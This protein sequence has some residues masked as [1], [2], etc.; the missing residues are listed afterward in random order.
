[1]VEQEQT[2][3]NAARQN[4][5]QAQTEV[6]ARQSQLQQQSSILQSQQQQI[7]SPA[8]SRALDISGMRSRNVALG[9]IGS[10]QAGVQQAQ[11]QLGAASKSLSEYETNVLQPIEQQIKNVQA[12]QAEWS[13]AFTIAGTNIP[14]TQ[15]SKSIQEKVDLIRNNQAAE[16]QYNLDVKAYNL[17]QQLNKAQV[18]IPKPIT[19]TQQTFTLPAIKAAPTFPQQVTISNQPT[20]QFVSSVGEP[21]GFFVFAKNLP[22]EAGQFV[23]QQ[24]SR[25]NIKPYTIPE[26]NV[27]IPQRVT[28]GGYPTFTIPEQKTS[29]SEQAGKLIGAGTTLGIYASPVGNLFMGAS[30]IGGT[31]EALNPKLPT[32]QRIA[33]GIEAGVAGLILGSQAYQAA[34]KPIVQYNQ[35]PVKQSFV[36]VQKPV[37]DKMLAK[38]VITQEV[39]PI[40]VRATTPF[41]E[42]F[43][44]QPAVEGAI[45]PT[46]IIKTFTP[47]FVEVGK[48]FDFVTQ[49]VGSKV[50]YVSRISGQ[51]AP[52]D[53]ATFQSLPKTY[54]YVW[55]KIAERETGVPVSLENTPKVLRENI[56]NIQSQIYTQDIYK[57]TQ[58]G[59]DKFRVDIQTPTGKTFNQY[60]AGTIQ[61]EVPEQP[62]ATFD[63]QYAGSPIGVTPEGVKT[64]KSE[65]YFK[66]VTF[67]F[68]RASGNVPVLKGTTYLLGGAEEATGAGIEAAPPSKIINIAGS[69]ITITKEVPTTA[70]TSVINIAGQPITITREIPTT[71]AREGTSALGQVSSQVTQATQA[72]S[73]PVVV[74][75]IF[76]K[77]VT[78]EVPASLTK[79]ASSTT[80]P[81]LSSLTGAGLITATKAETS[82]KQPQVSKT[83]QIESP[84]L[85]TATKVV[86]IPKPIQ[87]VIP[88]EVAKNVQAEVPA[89]A[90]KT[91]QLEKQVQLQPLVTTQQKVSQDIFTPIPRTTLFPPPSFDLG[92]ETKALRKKLTRRQAYNVLYKRRGKFLEYRKG[93]PLGK[94]LKAGAEITTST[95][96][97]TFK[98]VPSGT[99]ESLDISY[100]PSSQVFRQPKKLSPLTF[101]QRVALTRGTQEIP[102]IMA[103]KRRAKIFKPKRNRRLKLI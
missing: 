38:Y 16:K 47:D 60:I 46:K 81:I 39:P 102:E 100:F 22:T 92:T 54:Q 19:T 24:I 1:M 45:T 89:L 99:T 93:L 69:P 75:K 12:E 64:F 27:F 88:L 101:V 74:P 13:S 2:N 90:F 51:S 79:L 15:Y 6:A 70:S 94:A 36:E 68:A 8:V 82:F 59:A 61:K 4:L 85:I 95:L 67:P 32:G 76:P 80:T 21:Q 66:D 86:E 84:S 26:Q 91:E 43:G 44:M 29:V 31:Q 34:T 3:V 53:K 35:E 103:A 78:T 20:G 11:S 73:K 87:N 65:T 37:G 98:L 17:Q 83:L 71:I 7:L 42:F 57:L 97:R 72:V 55:Q 50:Y 58:T 23:S 25:T 41:R 63:M 48:P 18:E 77:I 62:L 5:V 40:T 14:A 56:Q 96:A 28:T 9:Q 33:G 10:Q 49:Q 52:L 30:L